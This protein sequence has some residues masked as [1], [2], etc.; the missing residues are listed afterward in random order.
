LEQVNHW[1]TARL[2][3]LCVEAGVRHFIY[4]STAAVYGPG[5]PFS[6][7]DAC[8]PMGAY[9]QSKLKAEHVVR[10]AEGRGM[11]SVILRLGTLFGQAPRMRFDAVVNRFA[12][13]A[14]VGRPLT[15]FGSGQQR[16][17]SIHVRD[18]AQLISKLIA[19]PSESGTTLNVA[20]DNP[21]V[22][23]V[24]DAVLAL[25][26]DTR[27]RYTEQ[28]VLTYLSLELDTSRLTG[29]GFVPESDIVDGLSEVL[30]RFT[31]LVPAAYFPLE[32]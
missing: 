26:P 25:R 4:A 11:H 22:E 19:T 31:G 7:V 5:G 24:K 6:E 8:R 9:A 3:D 12:Y 2:V 30:D 29:V 13:L 28:D 15:V 32:D 27:V 23:E 21:S 10:E 1:G 14:G 20:V 17:P 16:R 18:A